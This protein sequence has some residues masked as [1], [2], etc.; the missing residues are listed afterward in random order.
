[1]SSHFQSC[2]DSG[3]FLC[4]PCSSEEYDPVSSTHM[5]PTEVVSGDVSVIYAPSLRELIGIH[6]SGVMD[7]DTCSK[8]VEICMEGCVKIRQRVKEYLELNNK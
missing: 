7:L 8:G 3:H 2:G 4:D 1:M 6:Q 5:T